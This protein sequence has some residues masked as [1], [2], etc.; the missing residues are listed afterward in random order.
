MHVWIMLVYFPTTWFS[1]T[2]VLVWKPVRCVQY[3]LEPVRC[4]QYQLEP[5]KCVQYHT[6]ASHLQRVLVIHDA[7]AKQRTQSLDRLHHGVLMQDL[8]QS[9]SCYLYD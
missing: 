2:I 7:L 3:Q 4:V 1:R 5:V 6:E 8:C 9:K